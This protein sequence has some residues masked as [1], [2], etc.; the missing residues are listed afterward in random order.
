MC[1]LV[2]QPVKV[3]LPQATRRDRRPAP[4]TLSASAPPRARVVD[5]LADG[6]VAGRAVFHVAQ[7]ALRLM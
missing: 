5:R 2:D 4:S 1:Q 3:H 7:N 6:L